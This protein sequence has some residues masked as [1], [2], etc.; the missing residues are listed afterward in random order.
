M[1]GV[2]G[3]GG[4]CM[5]LPS[6]VEQSLERPVHVVSLRLPLHAMFPGLV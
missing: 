3:K 6:A 2:E 1:S 4:V 5:S